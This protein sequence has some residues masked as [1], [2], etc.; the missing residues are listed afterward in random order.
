MAGQAEDV[1]SVIFPQSL[2]ICVMWMLIYR[3]KITSAGRFSW[4]ILE[5]LNILPASPAPI[6]NRAICA[7][8]QCCAFSEVSS[9]NMV[10]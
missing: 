1:V 4:K 7:L 5:H 9:A 10:S 2:F 6:M 8:S 3:S